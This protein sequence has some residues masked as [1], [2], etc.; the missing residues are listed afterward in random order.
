MKDDPQQR[1]SASLD[2][3]QR[4]ASS[5]APPPLR[6]L[7]DL[8]PLPDLSIPPLFSSSSFLPA[9]LDPSREVVNQVHSFIDTCT[10][11]LTTLQSDDTFNTFLQHAGQAAGIIGDIGSRAPLVGVVFAALSA[12]GQCLSDAEDTRTGFNDLYHSASTTARLV[13]TA[14][15]SGHSTYPAQV[16]RAL[17][18]FWDAIYKLARLLYETR[19][20]GYVRRL[21]SDP[22]HQ[23]QLQRIRL[24]LDQAKSDIQLVAELSSLSIS[25]TTADDVREVMALLSPSQAPIDEAQYAAAI[26]IAYSRLL[27]FADVVTSEQGSPLRALGL[28]DVWVEQDVISSQGFGADELELLGSHV[29]FLRASGQ[30]DEDGEVAERVTAYGRLR[31]RRC[32]PV[33]SILCDARLRRV[34]MLGHPGMGKSSALR[35]CALQWASAS[36][37]ERAELAFPILVELKLYKAAKV[38]MKPGLTLLQY[39]CNG[40]SVCYSMAEAALVALLRSSRPVLLM[41]DGLD[42]LFA[43]REVVIADVKT[44]I[45]TFDVPN[46]RVVITS[47]IIGYRRADFDGHGFEQFTLQELSTEQISQFVHKWH[48]ATYTAVEQA[49]S[50][51]RK[52]R[53]L[54]AIKL[55]PSIEVLAKNP[56]LLTMICIVNRGPELPTKRVRLYDKCVELLLSQWQVELAKEAYTSTTRDILAFGFTEKHRLLRE[57]AWRMQDASQPLGLIVQQDVLEQLVCGHVKRMSETHGL[58]D[59]SIVTARAIID[60]LRARHYVISF[61]GGRSFAFVHRTFLEYF[62]AAH[63]QDLWNRREMSAE[64]LVELFHQRGQDSSWREVLCLLCGMLPSKHIAPCLNVLL[65]EPPGIRATAETAQRDSNDLDNKCIERIW[66]FDEFQLV[67]E[68]VEQLQDRTEAAAVV[69]RIRCLLV[70]AVSADLFGRLQLLVR[71]WPN[72]HG[73]DTRAA[74]IRMVSRR[75]YLPDQKLAV[76]TLCQRWPDDTTR[77]VL[78]QK[79]IDLA[80][81]DKTRG[82]SISLGNIVLRTL[83]LHWPNHAD[84]RDTL[85]RVGMGGPHPS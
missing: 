80:T 81:D 38:S 41:L 20:T 29:D 49:I 82:R 14:E 22:K 77:L 66:L 5:S 60:Q 24:Q 55:I 61:L 28:Q 7:A 84:T 71:L 85:E 68:C 12:V 1:T 56:L 10:S 76:T 65:S 30:L 13:Q 62:A 3:D 15:S 54:Q 74:L 16:Q 35:E 45:N 79:A 50:D 2:A 47:R 67:G 59:A 58:K 44:F 32:S 18:S 43:E 72:D 63:I 23:R 39:L 40:G 8:P 57:L 53:L 69:E 4:F 17:D 42:E 21:L 25:Q 75:W 9:V 83:V 26:C 11:T 19:G 73:E 78:V 37:E 27:G 33:L 48:A 34:V 64:Q 36:A 6:L 31:T 52:Q 70:A 51:A 46:M